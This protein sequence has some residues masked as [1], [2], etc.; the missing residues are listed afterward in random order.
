[1]LERDVALKLRRPERSLGPS[2]ERQF[3]DEARRL[4]KI[5]H[6]NVVTVHGA[7]I[8][9]GRMGIWMEFLSGTPLDDLP[10]T[11]NW[12]EAALIGMT[13]CQALGAVHAS[14]L[15]HRDVKP[16]NIFRTSSGNIVLLDLGSAADRPDRAAVDS[17]TVSGTPYFMAP[18]AWTGQATPASDIY[19]LGVTLFHLVSGKYPFTQR[20]VDHLSA[21]FPVPPGERLSLREAAPDVPL[22]FLQVVERAMEL[23]PAR[24]IANVGEM[25]QALAAVLNVPSSARPPTPWWR[26]LEVLTPVAAVA[27]VAVWLLLGRGGATAP[28]VEAG[29][30]AQGDLAGARSLG[31]GEVVQVGEQLY[32]D[33][34]PSR[35]TWVY[36]VTEDERGRV[37]TLFPAPGLD[38]RNPLRGG[39]SHRLPGRAG[40]RQRL[41]RVDTA[42]GRETILLVASTKPL[43]GLE[44]ELARF[45]EA[46]PPAGAAPAEEP[47]AKGVGEIIEVPEN[48]MIPLIEEFVNA[49]IRDAGAVVMRRFEF[50]S[51]RVLPEATTP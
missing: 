37:H 28:R 42:G 14:G 38:T 48:G 27:A 17:A 13:L 34:N 45:P 33:V 41:W 16:G 11:R 51:E 25:E 35:E 44:T 24:R 10:G 1:M 8:L 12:Q 22:P 5:K 31:G 32:L 49:E 6:P 39:T 46:A 50:R 18:E 3:L 30:F 19:S 47:I 36:V 2:E 23:D 21:G 40:G 29:L 15:V 26:R 9:D 7:D 43:E 4:G 20:G